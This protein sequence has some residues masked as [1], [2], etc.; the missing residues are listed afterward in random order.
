MPA[1]FL[2]RADESGVHADAK[3][4]VVAG[5]AG[6]RSQWQ[7]L[8]RDWTR[9]LSRYGI[10]AFHGKVY[11]NRTKITGARRNPYLS[12]SEH[13]ARSL[14]NE[15]IAV[16]VDN[17][18]T[19]VGGGVDVAA[20][21]SF[22]F[23]EQ[24]ALVGYWRKVGRG[25]SSAPVAYHLAFRMMLVDGAD[26]MTPGS[27][28]HFLQAEHRDYQQ[29]ALEAYST[30]RKNVP[31]HERRFKTFRVADPKGVPGL[32]AADLIAGQWARGWEAVL[33]GRPQT[34]AEQ[35]TIRLLGR[36]RLA[37]P[38]ADKAFMEELLSDMEHDLPGTR[39]GLRG[40]RPEIGW[41]ARRHQ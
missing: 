28:L 30:M 32:Q 5:Y 2:V 25:K 14:L 10:D 39:A 21:E 23:G 6:T 18:V 17:K 38:F 9:V 22:T 37:L 31:S 3:V 27:E 33:A 26:A 19:P 8:D 36:R 13:K 34:K 4:C 35:A 40:V 24:C 15:L 12:W 1:R 20:L 7:S 41:P 16:I 29:R 11:F